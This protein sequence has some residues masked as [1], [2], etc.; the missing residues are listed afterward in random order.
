MEPFATQPT[1]CVSGTDAL[2]QHQGSTAPMHSMC[3]SPPFPTPVEPLT[4]W[5]C[6][7]DDSF[8]GI[9]TCQGSARPKD[10]FDARPE[11]ADRDIMAEADQDEGGPLALDSLVCLEDFNGVISKVRRDL[12]CVLSCGVERNPWCPFRCRKLRAHR[13][14]GACSSS[15]GCMLVSAFA[16]MF[17]S[18]GHVHACALIE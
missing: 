10:L 11:D 1:S 16:G 9:S 17:R 4:G 12:S 6:D 3:M 7:R 18:T 15:K 2:F 5:P 8:R 13:L 14:R